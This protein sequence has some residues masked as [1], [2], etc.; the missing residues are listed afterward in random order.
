MTESSSFPGGSN[1]VQLHY[2]APR[3]PVARTTEDPEAP[4]RDP[5]DSSDPHGEIPGTESDASGVS[6]GGQSGV[7]E[8]GLRD[9]QPRGRTSRSVLW[10][11]FACFSLLG[12]GERCQVDKRF[13]SPS[14]TLSTYWQALLDGDAETAWSCVDDGRPG[15]PMP[16]MIWFLPPS[17]T[18]RLTN[19][20]AL[21]VTNGRV[22][23]RYDVE[24]VPRGVAE[25]RAFENSDELVRRRGEWRLARRV[26]EASFPDWEPT[27]QPIDS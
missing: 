27:R 5:L 16:G 8:A 20:R 25:V 7:A 10:L 21:P 17:D 22:M 14:A 19:I 2:L 6:G 12:Q 24:F 15:L 26:G 4:A 9:A 13:A 3:T 1:P 23:V 11:A 18:L